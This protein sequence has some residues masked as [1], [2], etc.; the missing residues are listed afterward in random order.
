MAYSVFDKYRIVLLASEGCLNR[1]HV[2]FLFLN[3]TS[4]SW[5][6][7]HP[8]DTDE[9]KYVI[10]K[11]VKDKVKYPKVCFTIEYHLCH[12]DDQSILAAI[13]PIQKI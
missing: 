3:P 2:D 5:D 12:I 1:H 10:L 8:Y 4:R 13:V 11:T 6:L 9:L 7:P